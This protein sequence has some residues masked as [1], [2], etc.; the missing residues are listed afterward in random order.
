M[1]DCGCL[2]A[3]PAPQ[4]W[5]SVL[6]F[7]TLPVAFAGAIIAIR[8]YWSNA[9]RER[10]KW[11]VQLWEKFY[12]GDRY[13]EMRDSLDSPAFSPELQE[14]IEE[15]P[16]EFSDYLNFFELV[17]FL[18]NSKQLSKSDVLGVF[19]YYLGC[20]KRS[21]P[22]MQFLNDRNN[23]FEHLRDFFKKNED[24]FQNL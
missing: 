14:L 8:T 19:Q 7:A 12:E 13:K 23:G 2:A 15:K 20:M 21:P 3:N 10:A 11:T 1:V 6:E 18:A 5:K 24:S 16:S 22:V 17:L 9:Q 4:L